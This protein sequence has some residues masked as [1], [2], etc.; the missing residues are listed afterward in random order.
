MP[1]DRFTYALRQEYVKLLLSLLTLLV[2]SPAVA[3]NKLVATYTLPEIP[4]KSFQN[5]VLPGSVANDRKV[6]LG[7]LGSD[8]WRGPTD[9]PGEFWMISD[10]GP[11]GQIRVDG[12]NRRTFW[13]PEFNPAIV[14]VKLDGSEIRIVETTHPWPIGTAR[15]R[16][17]EHQR[18]R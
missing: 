4:I 12:K 10:R 6:L 15:H 18:L 17:A 7:S 9:A 3:Q 5:S 1:T 16:I 11:N 14:K 13:I 8:L 2:A